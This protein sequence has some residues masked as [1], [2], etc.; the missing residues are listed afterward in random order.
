MGKYEAKRQKKRGLSFF[1][2]TMLVL[3][4]C[5]V[6]LCAFAWAKYIT[7]QQRDTQVSTKAFYFESDLLDGESH[8]LPAGAETLS[9]TVMNYP[10][11]L[12]KA[13]VDIEFTATLLK[14]DAALQELNGVLLMTKGSET[15]SFNVANMEPGTYSVRCS[16]VAPYA[17]TLTGTFTL[18]SADSF[19][20][21]SVADGSGNP[22]CYL[23]V[24]VGDYN[25]KVSIQWPA[26]VTPD[27]Q[28]PAA[29]EM[30]FASN[31]EYKFTFFKNNILT[32]YDY[33]DFTVEK[34]SN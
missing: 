13:E 12:R 15:V 28:D 23:T 9:F 5:A 29:A 20:D 21:H 17:K 31:S 8:V 22:V 14:G 27:P 30:T 18:L 2:M 3:L 32:V 1:S 6:A 24:K 34:I 25:G 26:G 16:A 4:V 19:V 10:D 33:D 7:S 11:A